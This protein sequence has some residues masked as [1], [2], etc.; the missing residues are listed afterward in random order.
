M[1]KIITITLSLFAAVAAIAQTSVTFNVEHLLK[2]KKFALNQAATTNTNANFSVSRLQYY[3][4]NIS[5]IHDGGTVT[6]ATGVYILA[7]ASKDLSQDLGKYN[8]TTIEGIKF[9]IGVGKPVNNQDPTQWPS[10]HPL[11]PQVPSMHWGWTSG[12]RFVALE[13]AEGASL[14]NQFELH[15]LGNNYFYNIQ[16]PLSSTDVFGVQHITVKAD[17]TRALENIDISG[18][19]VVHGEESETIAMLRNFRDFVFTSSTGA[20][21]ILASVGGTIPSSAL[22]IYPNPTSGVVDFD[23][24]NNN[25]NI[26]SIQISDVAGRVIE[27]LSV[28]GF[29]ANQTQLTAKGIYLVSLISENQ[30]L[31]TKKL[32]VQ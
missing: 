32:I 21:N 17:Y 24:T 4:S 14:S 12:Y 15:A 28:N 8:F 10:T 19:K 9:S 7:D 5:I 29:G 22:N 13:G 25:Y 16:I 2:D 27:T 3:I 26:T 6:P 18:G 20:G 11:S 23:I 1:K 30:R 31:L